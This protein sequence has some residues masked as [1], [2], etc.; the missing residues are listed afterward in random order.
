[1]LPI[2]SSRICD[3]KECFKYSI[4]VENLAFEISGLTDFF[5]IVK[6]KVHFFT[7]QKGLVIIILAECKARN[8]YTNSL[9]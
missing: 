3:F 9:I 4:L 2:V 6:T 7:K 5:S 1:M 8:K